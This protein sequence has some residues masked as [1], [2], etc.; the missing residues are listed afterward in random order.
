MIAERAIRINNDRRVLQAL[1]DKNYKWNE[2]Q[3]VQFNHTKYKTAFPV[4]Q[5]GIQK[6]ELVMNNRQIRITEDNE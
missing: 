1:P 4:S 2:D 5:H 3:Y 6:V